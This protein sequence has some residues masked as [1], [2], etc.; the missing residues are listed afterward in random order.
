MDEKPPLKKEAK[1]TT[2]EMRGAIIALHKAGF[3]NTDISKRLDVH[4]NTVSLWLNRF[5]NEGNTIRK[6]RVNYDINRTTTKEEDEAI[7]KYA[8]EH[9]ISTKREIKEKLKVNCSINTIRARLIDAGLKL[10]K[11][12]RKRN[13]TDKQDDPNVQAN[14]RMAF[15]PPFN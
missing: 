6:Q 2:R 12:S 11:P 10:Y 8:K 14:K 9:P 1:S 4:R 3:S 5:K 15:F 7:I 13:R